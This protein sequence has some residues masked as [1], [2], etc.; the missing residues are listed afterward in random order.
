ML[1]RLAG[2]GSLCAGAMSV[3]ECT[4]LLHC[5][6]PD[7]SN[8]CLDLKGALLDT[9][10]S[11]ACFSVLSPIIILEVGSKCEAAA[12]CSQNFAMADLGFCM[13]SWSLVF[14]E[15]KQDC[16]L[17]GTVSPLCTMEQDSV[18][19]LPGTRFKLRRCRASSMPPSPDRNDLRITNKAFH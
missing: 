6:V 7:P 9:P 10:V 19:M 15:C 4:A 18:M 5:A 14:P 8:V 13:P 3:E 2:S 1:Y 12:S 11:K 17:S 16:V